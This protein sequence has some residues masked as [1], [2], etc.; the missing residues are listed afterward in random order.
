MCRLLTLPTLAAAGLSWSALLLGAVLIG[1]GLTA[2]QQSMPLSGNGDVPPAVPTDVYV[3]TYLD[4]L[5]AVDDTNYEFQA[6]SRS[7]G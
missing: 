4:R 6:S 5:L 1:A 7:Q 2:A 3:S